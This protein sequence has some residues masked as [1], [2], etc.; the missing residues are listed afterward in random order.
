M[1]EEKSALMRFREILREL[2]PQN[3]ETLRD[4]CV[5][6]A[7]KEQRFSGTC[8]PQSFAWDRTWQQLQSTV[9]TAI[10]YLRM[11]RVVGRK[12]RYGIRTVRRN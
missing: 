6:L 12:G 8:Y 7:Q 9:E 4:E 2:S 5:L 3:W 1:S 11:R 10:S